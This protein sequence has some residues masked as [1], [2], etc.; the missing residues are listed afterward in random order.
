MFEAE[1]LNHHKAIKKAE[2]DQQRKQE[3]EERAQ[4][5]FTRAMFR[6]LFGH[7][8]DPQN[9]VTINGCLFL[10]FTV[11]VAEVAVSIHKV[12]DD[13]EGHNYLTITICDMVSRKT[14]TC[15]FNENQLA[16]MKPKQRRKVLAGELA[17]TT[18]PLSRMKGMGYE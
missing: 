8:L 15:L 13:D 14:R 16:E 12:V 3:A 17:E 4:L 10:T 11:G 18:F 6:R 9:S 2:L 7:R 1:I 5:D